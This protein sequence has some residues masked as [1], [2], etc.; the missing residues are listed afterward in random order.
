MSRRVYLL[1]VGLALVALALALAFTDWALTFQPGVTEANA[2]RLRPGMT[3]DEV[4]AVMGERGYCLD[5]FSVKALQRFRQIYP[6]PWVWRNAECIVVARCDVNGRIER[7][8]WA[9]IRRPQSGPVARL[10]AWLG[11]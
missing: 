1:G 2:K 5:C 4:R 10:R 6:V 9:P 8:S 3:L 7:V 11:W